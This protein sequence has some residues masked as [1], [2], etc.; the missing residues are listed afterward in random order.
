MKNKLIWFFGGF[1]V[2]ITLL[3]LGHAALPR[4]VTPQGSSTNNTP[5]R[6]QTSGQ[7]N[8]LTEL[9]PNAK[10]TAP[11]LDQ[12]YT[13]LSNLEGQYAESADQ[14]NRLKTATSKV[15][16]KRSNQ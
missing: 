2:G 5:T 11:D 8:N 14:Q 3:S 16:R 15:A 6:G 12:D 7:T 1:G 9:N 13:K 10:V 4:R